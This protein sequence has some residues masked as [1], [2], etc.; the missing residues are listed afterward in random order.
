MSNAKLFNDVETMSKRCL[1]MSKHSDDEN[2]DFSLFDE[3]NSLSYVESDDSKHFSRQLHTYL[4]RRSSRYD[5][6]PMGGLTR[7]IDCQSFRTFLRLST[8][9]TLRRLLPNDERLA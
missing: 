5:V 3:F 2:V 7:D 9:C 8:D 4:P 6:G 1:T